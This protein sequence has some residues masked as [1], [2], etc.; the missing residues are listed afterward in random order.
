[1]RY[2]ICTVRR[3]GVDT[4]GAQAFIRQVTGNAGRSAL[5]HEGFGLPPR[6]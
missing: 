6:G 2:Q 1:V 3:S 5:K 4:R